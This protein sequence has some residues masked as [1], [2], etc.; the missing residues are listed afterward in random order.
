MKQTLKK[1]PKNNKN[2]FFYYY[3][4]RITLESLKKGNT[5]SSYSGRHK[6]G[7]PNPR[8]N[9]IKVRDDKDSKAKLGIESVEIAE[10]RAN[11]SDMRGKK[12]RLEFRGNHPHRW[13][14]TS[15]FN[16]GY[17]DD[18][19]DAKGG[20]AGVKKGGKNDYVKPYGDVKNTTRPFA[21][22]DVERHVRLKVK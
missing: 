20:K 19:G 21:P 10:F 5:H 13:N 3:I 12:N 16:S 2:I 1:K 9:S 15:Q 7:T 11:N 14:P 22:N 6:R 8:G 4:M 17:T 18:G